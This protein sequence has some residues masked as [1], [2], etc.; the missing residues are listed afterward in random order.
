NNFIKKISKKFPKFWRIF[1][2]IGI[3][4]SFGLI[5]FGFYFFFINLISLIVKPTVQNVVTPLIPGVTIDIPTIMYIILPLLF[6][7]TTHELAHGIAATIDGVE[8][9]SSGILGA[10]F[11]F[12]IGGGAFVE[13][14]ERELASK[15]V[16]RKTRLRI[17]AAGTFVNVITAGIALLIIL[18][19]PL[20][21]SPF[22]GP[23]VIQ[24]DTVYQEKEGGFNHNNINTGDVILGLKK[25][26]SDEFLK[27]DYGNNKTLEN[28][29]YNRTDKISCSV[30]DN[31]TLKVYIPE[32]DIKDERA[33][34][35][36]PKYKIGILYE[37]ISNSEMKITK[38][39]S[40]DEGGNN[41]DIELEE[42]TIITEINNTDIN[43][44]GGD[45]LESILT[46]KD[47]KDVKLK[48]KNGK[49]YSLDVELEG[50]LIGIISRSYWMPL[51]SLSKLFTGEFPNFLLREFIW[52]WIIAFSIALFNM[53]PLPIFDGDR[54]LKEVINWGIGEEYEGTKTKKEKFLFEPDK[55]LYE[56]SEYR[57]Q[58][59]KKAKLTI[60]SEDTSKQ[61][62]SS[63]G[64]NSSDII[65]AENKFSLIDS[66]EDGF[67]DAV[68]LEFE[69]KTLPENSILEIEYE[70]LHDKK[71]KTK[72]IIL[73]TLRVITLGIVAANFILSFLKFGVVT[74]W[75]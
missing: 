53:L 46:T 43:V 38:I 66:L 65:I 51:N 40:K 13:V 2:S 50:V 55:K 16:E 37:Y 33:I 56:L 30:G 45:T 41:Y 12:L 4:V 48:D 60:K 73:N 75:M 7:M 42:G 31:L 22:Y 17:A 39:Y 26:S 20:L 74:F 14:D 59:I 57:V 28:Y 25:Q 27:L 11:F 9:K 54:V 6:I 62:R 32:K 8:V 52:L 47:L 5:I 44:E 70:Y 3:F 72:K 21:I 64:D 19:F 35:L 49:V 23:Q 71:E 36:G 67:Q 58:G 10:G 63:E 61:F 29:L 68:T 24:V 1:W 34:E 15:K 69:N 18:S